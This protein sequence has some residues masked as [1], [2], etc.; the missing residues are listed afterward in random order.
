MSE[1]ELGSGTN[2][3]KT[4]QH[5]PARDHTL[6]EALALRMVDTYDKEKPPKTHHPR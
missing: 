6:T 2:G 5:G 1:D 4:K 3:R